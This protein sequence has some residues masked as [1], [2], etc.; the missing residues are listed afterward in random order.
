MKRMGE[1]Y[2]LRRGGRCILALFGFQWKALGMRAIADGREA[3]IDLQVSG[4]PKKRRKAKR[5]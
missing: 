2:E 4:L 3:V 1:H 5:K